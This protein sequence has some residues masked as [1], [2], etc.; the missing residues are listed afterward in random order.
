M[1]VRAFVYKY[2]KPPKL[3]YT[4]EGRLVSNLKRRGIETLK[5]NVV[6]NRGWPDRLILLQGGK[7]L[8][9][10]LKRPGESLRPLQEHVHA[11]LRGLGYEIAVAY[12]NEG[13]DALLAKIDML[14]MKG[15]R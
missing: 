13:V 12:D 6:G 9:A 10:E 5:L 1:S 14:V 4:V 15:K 3:E 8:L 7:P 11:R 2:R